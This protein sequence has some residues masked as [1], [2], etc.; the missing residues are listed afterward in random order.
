MNVRLCSPRK[1]ADGTVEWVPGP[2]VTL[3]PTGNMVDNYHEVLA[4]NLTL[5][6]RRYCGAI[7]LR[8]ITRSGH[9]GDFVRI[10]S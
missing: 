6:A 7:R 9:L 10:A 8:K 1:R 4:G 3:V 2:T 5:A